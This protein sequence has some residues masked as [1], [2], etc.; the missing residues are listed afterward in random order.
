MAIKT[1]D[2]GSGLI[3]TA[4]PG[5]WLVQSAAGSLVFVAD[6]AGAWLPAIAVPPPAPVVVTPPPVVTPPVVVAPPPVVVIT[7]P[8]VVTPPPSTFTR[9]YI[10]TNLMPQVDWAT[11][12][13][14]LNHVHRAVAPFSGVHFG[15]W[16]DGKVLNLDARGN[17]LSLAP[18]Q[19]ARHVV[20]TAERWAG[21]YV[22][23]WQGKGTVEVAGVKVVDASVP[24]QITVTVPASGTVNIDVTAV[25]VATP[26]HDLSM[27][28][29]DQLGLTGLFNPDFIAAMKLYACIRF[30]DWQGTNFTRT[31]ASLAADFAPLTALP[32]AFGNTWSGQANG[33]SIP[34]EVMIELCNKTGCDGWF[35]MPIQADAAWRQKFYA[36]VKAKLAPGL[37]CYVENSN[38]VWNGAF[39]QGHFYNADFTANMNAHAD[40]SEVIAKE[41]AAALP[42]VGVSVLGSWAAVS[43]WTDQLLARMQKAGTLPGVVAIAPYFGGGSPD[44]LTSFTD[45]T[46]AAQVT[47]AIGWA[48]SSKTVADKY[49]V[50]LVCYEGGMSQIPGTKVA[51]D[52]RMG[53]VYAGYL[54]Q[55]RALTGGNLF[56]HYAFVSNWG[57]SGSWGLKPAQY[58]AETGKSK[59]VA[60]AIAA[61]LS[62]P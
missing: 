48:K 10:G 47:Q 31:A 41:V 40:A 62:K 51:A 43:F 26:L 36:L 55:W 50:P 52:D 2:I 9:S 58:A 15:L 46:M 24:N 33:T 28:R 59:A 34:L 12:F 18:S 57:A 56:N 54:E 38:E 29:K 39:P 49:A 16:N 32:V 35:C 19:V 11:D 6:A 37:K 5:G 3:R 42:G 25:D 27:V 30:M 23:S 53:P 4:V 20:F 7:P 17:V 1:E 8:P 13:P 14:F 22:V 45:G 61:H 21:D 44:V 60:A